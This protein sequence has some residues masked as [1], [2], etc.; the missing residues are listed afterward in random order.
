MTSTVSCT[1]NPAN[2]GAS[3]TCTV[4]CTNVGNASANNAFCQVTNASLPGADGGVFAERHGGSGRQ[5]ELYVKLR[6]DGQPDC[7]TGWHGADNDVNG[8]TDPTAGNN[9]PL[10]QSR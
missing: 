7:G 5:P 10:L 8:G 6:G 3:V 9:P 1:P 4:T 2:A